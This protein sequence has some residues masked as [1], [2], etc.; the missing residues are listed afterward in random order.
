MPTPS[1]QTTVWSQQT[2][3]ERNIVNHTWVTNDVSTT[4]MTKQTFLLT[5][6]AIDSREDTNTLKTTSINQINRR[7]KEGKKP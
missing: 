3:E 2:R 6:N 4:V 5:S 1:T 7:R